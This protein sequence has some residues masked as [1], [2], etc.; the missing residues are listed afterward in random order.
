LLPLQEEIIMTPFVAWS[1]QFRP[2]RRSLDRSPRRARSA[3][4]MR[5]RR[6]LDAM[7]D[8]TLLSTLTVTNDQD[9]GPG[10]LRAAIA[11]AAAGDTIDFYRIQGPPSRRSRPGRALRHLDGN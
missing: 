7:K 1:K 8:R 4:R 10:S 3:L 9:S 2:G 6:R 11:K 5:F